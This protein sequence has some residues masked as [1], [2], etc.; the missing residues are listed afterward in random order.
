MTS[1]LGNRKLLVV[2]LICAVAIGAGVTAGIHFR[3]TGTVVF[4]PSHLAL[5][6]KISEGESRTFQVSLYN[7]L[8]G[9]ATVD[10][11]ITTCGCVAL[12]DD[13]LCPFT[14]EPRSRVPISFRFKSDGRIGVGR[15]DLIARFRIGSQQA[16]LTGCSID[17]F[18]AA[19]LQPIPGQIA[20][21]DKRAGDVC[22]ADLTL[23]DMAPG[24]NSELL[25]IASSNTELLRIDKVAATAIPIQLFGYPAIGRYHVAIAFHVP[26]S[27]GSEPARDESLEASLEVKI[28]N[29]GIEFAKSIKVACQVRSSVRC[30]PRSLVINDANMSDVR[31]DVTCVCDDHDARELTVLSSPDVVKVRVRKSANAHIWVI[32]ITIAANLTGANDGDVKMQFDNGRQFRLPIHVVRAGA[33]N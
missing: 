25:D 28:R 22:R 3:N 29:K 33:D 14:I 13:S 20:W 12:V 2:A 18:V 7:P 15:S 19:A 4:D 23:A 27:P 11:V 6:D 17:Y 5:D 32:G 30:F 26:P 16:L 24:G 31:R 10:S 21:E 9:P 1:L 8:D